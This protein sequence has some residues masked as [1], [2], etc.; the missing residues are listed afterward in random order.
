[1]IVVSATFDETP[2]SCP[3]ESGEDGGSTGFLFESTVGSGVVLK[4]SWV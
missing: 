4:W 2:N 1:M 3:G